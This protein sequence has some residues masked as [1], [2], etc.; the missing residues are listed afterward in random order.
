MTKLLKCLLHKPED[1][2]LVPS[3]HLKKLCVIS[4]LGNPS[5]WEGM[6]RQTPRG[7]QAS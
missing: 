5:S 7:P 2:S 4:I 1:Q 3:T 6:D